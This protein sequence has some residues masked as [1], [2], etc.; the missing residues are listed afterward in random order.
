M[1]NP[2]FDLRSTRRSVLGSAITSVL[3]L[4]TFGVEG[5]GADSDTDQTATDE[6]ADVRTM[7]QKQGVSES[8]S[9]ER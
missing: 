3:G 1:S 9:S 8:P 4:G 6:T 7:G 5:V 2:R